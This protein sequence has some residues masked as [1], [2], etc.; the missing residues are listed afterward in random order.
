MSGA[1]WIC[2]HLGAR[3]HYA[4]PRALHLSGSLQLLIT[5]AW[6]QPRSPWRS[7]PTKLA[8]RLTERFHPD[9]AT[10]PVRHFTPSLTFRE[11]W[12]R[13]GPEDGWE[14]LMARNQWFGERAAAALGRLPD[15][16]SLRPLVFAHSYSAH[17]VFVAAKSRGWTT[18]LGQ[19]DPGEEH[20]R[21]V[22]RLCEAQP[23]YGPVPEEPPAEYFK[24]WRAECALADR[25]VVN[26]EWSRDCLQQSGIPASKLRVIPLAYEPEGAP[27]VHEHDYPRAFSAARPLRV[28]FVGHA[29]VAKGTA[30]LLEAVEQMSDAPID[31]HLV[32]GVA[33][34]VPAPFREHRAIH[35]VGP[36]SR[37]EVMRYYRESDVLVFPSHSDGFG[38]A[39][40][41]AQAWRLP[42]VA[43]RFCGRV[44]EHG[45][46]GIVLPEVSAGAIASAL[47]QLLADPGGL[48]ALSRRSG[49]AR[50][51]GLAAV[52]DGL[53]ALES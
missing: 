28:L 5:D 9:L 13:S 20:F 4:V 19:I 26:S 47:R 23:Q 16:S 39:Q 7:V 34:D 11:A 25:I 49:A 53:G 2:C 3:E 29:S 6:V 32:G 40:I 35:W 27:P 12:W 48:A 21:A 44:V 45:I 15:Q 1:R 8:R 17:D 37:S 30:A 41:E 51:P 33:M 43:S 31:L 22:R 10:A 46:N 52:R 36:V 50:L 42:V 24:S 38:M 18:V 14:R